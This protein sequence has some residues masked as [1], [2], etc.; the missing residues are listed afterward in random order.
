MVEVILYEDGD[1]LITTQIPKELVHD[2]KF[3]EELY[4]KALD[5]I[6]RI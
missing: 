3:R 4:P 5:I 1:T 2:T 6:R